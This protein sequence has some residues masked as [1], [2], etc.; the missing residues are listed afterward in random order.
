MLYY[1]YISNKAENSVLGD[2]AIYAYKI[3]PKPF[4]AHLSLN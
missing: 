3:D 2:D 1:S 4:L